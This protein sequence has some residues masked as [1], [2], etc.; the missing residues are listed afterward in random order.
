MADYIQLRADI[1]SYL[2]EESPEFQTQLDSIIQA[3]QVRICRELPLA[4][5]QVESTGAFSSGVPFA[6]LPS[7]AVAMVQFCVIVSGAAVPLRPRAIDWITEY[8]PDRSATSIQPKYWA[9]FDDDSLL[10]APTPAT[11]LDWR[12][13]TRQVKSPLGPGQLTNELTSRH[14]DLLLYSCCARGAVWLQDDRRQAMIDRFEALYLR[15]KGV[16][17]DNDVES[18]TDE[19]TERKPPAGTPR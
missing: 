13:T 18:R 8:W 19:Y 11:A 10:V 5:L 7:T 3:G 12:M 1:Q 4:I 15:E 6:A 17:I 14:Y 9:P 2:D 16:R